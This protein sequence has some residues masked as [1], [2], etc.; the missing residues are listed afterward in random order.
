MNTTGDVEP[1]RADSVEQFVGLMKRLK[2]ASGLTYRQLEERA[3]REGRVLPRS[4]IADVLRRQALP[5]P[6][7]LN[8]FV[9]ACGAGEHAETWLQARNRLAL[10]SGS[11]NHSMK[12]VPVRDGRAAPSSP[13][14]DDTSGPSEV[15]GAR[16]RDAEEGIGHPA[17]QSEPGTAP[18]RLLL[19]HRFAAPRL[20]VSLSTVLLVGIASW[21]VLPDDPGPA[22]TAP[23]SRE[24]A[25]GWYSIRPVRATDLCVTEGREPGGDT[26]AVQRPCPQ[27]TPPYTRLDPLGGGRFFVKW[28]HPVN[29]WGCLTVLTSGLL[30]PWDDC[31][32]SRTAQVFTFERVRTAGAPA[33]STGRTGPYRIRAASDGRCI[34]ISGADPKAAS[35]VAVAGPCTD[36]PSQHFLLA[37][38][39]EPA[40]STLPSVSG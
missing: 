12:E 27:S 9:H 18:R 6:H 10:G 38:E 29:G 33:S 22:A 28:V 2:D 16:G 13:A 1:E 39:A 32:S 11:A 26:V 34:G 19:R 40:A 15:G 21:L 24:P 17:I 30:E 8:A 25:T 36:S 35:A 14:D 20:W 37:P 31:R 5:R 7:M 23:S 4:T 3:E